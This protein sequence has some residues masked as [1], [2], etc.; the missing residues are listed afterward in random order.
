MYR[1]KSAHVEIKVRSTTFVDTASITIY[2]I[3]LRFYCKIRCEQ[4]V[5]LDIALTGGLNN[6]RHPASQL[7]PPHHHTTYSPECLISRTEM[8]RRTCFSPIPSPFVSSLLSSS[9]FAIVC[10]FC[11]RSNRSLSQQ[12]QERQEGLFPP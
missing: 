7:L 12:A 8:E 1:P 11:V 3:V 5:E 6:R 2:L 9:S 10:L 4:K